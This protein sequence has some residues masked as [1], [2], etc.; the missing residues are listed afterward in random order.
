MFGQRKHPETHEINALFFSW[1]LILGFY[2][3]S[4]WFCDVLLGFDPGVQSFF[5]EVSDFTCGQLP[6]AMYIY[7]YIFFFFMVNMHIYIS[8]MYRAVPCRSVPKIFPCRKIRAGPCQIKNPCQKTAPGPA[9]EES[10]PKI[11][12]SLSRRKT[13]GYLSACG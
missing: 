4:F 10:V 5:S 2:S 6:Y 12:A 13:C 9:I 1:G 11:C 7:I 8:G 3:F